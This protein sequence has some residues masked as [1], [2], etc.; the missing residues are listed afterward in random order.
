[1]ENA[2]PNWQDSLDIR[3]VNRLHRPLRQP[4]LMK[5]AMGQNII[6]RCD[7]FL[8]RLPLLSQQM[9]RW[10]NTSI[11]NS[12]SVPIVY[13]Q[14]IPTK[15]QQGIGTNL[16]EQ[17]S[18]IPVIQRK[19]NSAASSHV[20]NDIN[21]YLTSQSQITDTQAQINKTSTFSTEIPIVLPQILYGKLLNT[22]A[23]PLSLDTQSSSNN[24][25]EQKNNQIESIN[26]ANNSFSDGTS[27]NQPDISSPNIPVVSSQIINEQL[28]NTS[29]PLFSHEVISSRDNQNYQ[30]SN[31]NIKPLN[32]IKNNAINQNKQTDTSSTDIPIVP[33]QII[34]QNTLLQESL[35]TSQKRLPRIQIQQQIQQQSFP[36]PSSSTP[37]VNPSNT[38]AIVTTQIVRDRD[39]SKENRQNINSLPIVSTLP[40]PNS[41]LLPLSLVK[42]STPSTH[43]N[44]QTNLP[45]TN[46]SPS[47]KII[48]NSELTKQT[49]NFTTTNPTNQSSNIDI[50]TIATQVERKIMRR[51]VIESERRGKI[52]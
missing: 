1:M 6:N 49:S 41:Q 39:S 32:L 35:T 22:S 50:D 34:S 7:R 8:N 47:S 44:P 4:G 38:V 33:P 36:A 27:H 24:Q 19:V 10:G 46:S 5:M 31:Q 18:P 13:A 3:L 15:K 26:L 17:Q 45:N 20:S 12:D 40:H 48:T 43:I 16:A 30:P 42:V 9:Q 29:E 23:I 11:T 14:P 52:R 28:L 37:I 2:F 51:L 21:S 25:I